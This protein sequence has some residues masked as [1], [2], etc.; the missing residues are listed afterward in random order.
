MLY[1]QI[2]KLLQARVNCQASGN[3][4]WLGRHTAEALELVKEFAPSGSGFDS[5][6]MLDLTASNPEKLV[7]HTSFHHM[8]EN[9]YTH[10]TE[11][12]VT[13]RPSLAFGILIRVSG[14]NYNDIKSYI[15]DAFAQFLTFKVQTT[16]RT[17]K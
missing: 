1:S 6:T 17:A 4:E 3:A 14:R 13:V 15:H 10:W 16:K 12:T 9:G 5:G 11:H 8:N 2:A 7:F